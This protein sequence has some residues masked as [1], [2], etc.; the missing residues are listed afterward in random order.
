MMPESSLSAR[1]HRKA[2]ASRWDVSVEV[3]ARALDPIAHGFN[4][5]L[6]VISGFTELPI[7]GLETGDPLFDELRQVA[8]AAERGAAL[9]RQLLAFSRLR[10]AMLQRFVLSRVVQASELTVRRLA[11]ERIAIEFRTD[12]DDAGRVLAEAGQI[13]QSLVLNACAAM[14]SGGRLSITTSVHS[15]IG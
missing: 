15:R 14:A 7:A 4:N 3:F 8:L 1:L 10:D 2:R 13:E 12:A 11:G 9:T 6:T 5:L